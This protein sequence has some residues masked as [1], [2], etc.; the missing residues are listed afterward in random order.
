[1]PTIL[2][3]E[4]NKTI[5]ENTVEILEMEGYT[6]AT[7]ND[8]KKG[9]QKIIDLRPD[10]VIC[11][12]LMPEM[13]G[14]ELLAKLGLQTEL[15]NIPLI[16]YSAKSEKKVINQGMDLGAYDYIVKPSDLSDLLT[17]IRKCFTEKK[18]F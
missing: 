1:M 5:S 13:D 2:L 15:K 18:L 9:F 17:S 4:D 8:G 7:A 10:L 6:V 3:I 14:L 16:F 12:I 11:D